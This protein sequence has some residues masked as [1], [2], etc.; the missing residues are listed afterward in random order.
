MAQHDGHR[1]GGRIARVEVHQRL[2]DGLRRVGF[3]SASVKK[4]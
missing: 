1:A 4:R 3:S 2:V